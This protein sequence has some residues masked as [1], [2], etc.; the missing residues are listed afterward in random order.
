MQLCSTGFYNLQKGEHVLS[1][2][3]WSCKFGCGFYQHSVFTAST[4][5]LEV[6]VLFK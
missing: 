2:T 6:R 4:P 5:A 1:N 3:L